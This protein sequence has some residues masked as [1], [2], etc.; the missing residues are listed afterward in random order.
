MR[1]SS[2]RALVAVLVP[3]TLGLGASR[4]AA[5]T[6]TFPPAA[7]PIGPD[8]MDLPPLNPGPGQLPLEVLIALGLEA[9]PVEKGATA[10]PGGARWWIRQPDGRRLLVPGGAVAARA[11]SPVFLRPVL[12][13]TPASRRAKV[14]LLGVE[15]TVIAAV[16]PLPAG[17][18]YYYAAVP[19]PGYVVEGVW[20]VRADRSLSWLPA[21]GVMS[22]RPGELLVPDVVPQEAMLARQVDATP[23]ISDPYLAPTP[24]RPV[25]RSR[26]RRRVAAPRPAVDPSCNCVQPAATPTPSPA[27]ATPPKAAAPSPS[28]APLVAP[29]PT[30][31]LPKPGSTPPQTPSATTPGGALVTPAPAP[32]SGANATAGA[33]V[34]PAPAARPAASPSAS[35]SAPSSTAPATGRPPQR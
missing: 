3:V 12:T 18:R 14:D 29:T 17:R 19:T 1:F 20:H 24:V 31:P 25:V 6:Q 30:A 10:L 22:L 33:L 8:T 23:W 27:G 32:R 11:E 9:V 5:Q 28:P 2:S 4:L 15:D 21:S 13:P 35:P 26:P 7:P 16:R 34:T